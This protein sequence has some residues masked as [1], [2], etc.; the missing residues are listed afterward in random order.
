[1]PKVKRTLQGQS[2][3]HST[4][5]KIKL[6]PRS[7]QNRLVAGEGGVI[8]V[9]VTSPPVENRANKALIELLSKK[10]NISKGNIQI[11]SGRR[12]RLKTLEIDGLTL[13]EIRT[14]LGDG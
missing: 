1:M 9:Q 13:D 12:A 7:S 14:Y 2:N 4:R 3:E 11:V 8:K 10:L 5:I 6:N